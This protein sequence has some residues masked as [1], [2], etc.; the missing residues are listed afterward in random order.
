MMEPGI[1]NL[2][3]E[4]LAAG[5]FKEEVAANYALQ[6]LEAVEYLHRNGVM[7]RDLK[8]EN[9][10]CFGSHIK[11]TDFGWSIR[12]ETMRTTLCGTLDYMS[13]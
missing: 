9:V 7:H 6:V 8:P 4:I 3:Q 12:N 13:P 5:P 1:H 11:I 10:I 2:Y